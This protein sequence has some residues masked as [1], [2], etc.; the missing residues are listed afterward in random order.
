MPPV[1]AATGASG[2]V[3]REAGFGRNVLWS[4]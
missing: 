3:L 2:G 1:A 4:G